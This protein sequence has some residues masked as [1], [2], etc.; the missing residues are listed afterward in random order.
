MSQT[1][2]GRNT[3]RG[4]FNPN[5]IHLLL[6]EYRDRHEILQTLVF[7]V[8]GVLE[9]KHVNR[10]RSLFQTKFTTTQGIHK[11]V[12]IQKESKFIGKALQ[13]TN[14]LLQWS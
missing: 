7:L 11:I 4:L 14:E 6:T 8:V 10:R 12:K 13:E 3:Y 2:P 1:N 5:I 9:R